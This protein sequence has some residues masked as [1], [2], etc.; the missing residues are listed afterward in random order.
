MKD[1]KKI[2]A[3]NTLR[4]LRKNKAMFAILLV[5][6]TV[7][8]A[9]SGMLCILF[10]QTGASAQ[11]QEERYQKN[12][13]YLYDTSYLDNS[14]SYETYVNG[15]EETYGNLYA[16]YQELLR[17]D[18]FTFSPSGQPLTLLDDGRIPRKFYEN[19]EYGEETDPIL[20]GDRYYVNINAVPISPKGFTEF[21][22]E[23]SEGRLFT[24]EDF[25][26][27]EGKAIPILLGSEFRSV[28]QL[29]D[30]LQGKPGTKDDMEFEVVGFLK[31]NQ[32]FPVDMSLSSLDRFIVM[33]GFT[34]IEVPIDYE[35]GWPRYLLMQM[36]NGVMITKEPMEVRDYINGLCDATH[37]PLRFEVSQAGLESF[38]E[39]LSLTQETAQALKLFWLSFFAFTAVCV[40]LVLLSRLEENYFAY[41]VHLLSGARMRQVLTMTLWQ[42]GMLL[43]AS[44]LISGLVYFV[45]LPDAMVRVSLLMVDFYFALFMFVLVWA[46]VA[47][48]MR[49]MKIADWLRRPE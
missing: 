15:G 35:E 42:I 38:T 23:V 26:L 2:Y 9:V 5:Q 40:S 27:R 11:T 46:V 29:G 7:C 31:P 22:M 36:V 25:V 49:K 6:C 45:I 37:S 33:P 12:Y 48:R 18:R 32:A 24:Q 8:I 3:E 43:V 4:I 16:L 19:Y 17:Q 10:G 30:I 34:Q 21:G 39:I 44:L 14:S 47:V 13:Y 20:L 28:L 41:G 1:P